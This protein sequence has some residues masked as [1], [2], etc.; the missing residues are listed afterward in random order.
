MTAFLLNRRNEANK[1][2]KLSPFTTALIAET[3]YKNITILSR[4]AEARRVG[5]AMP[6]VVTVCDMMPGV[7]LKRFYRAGDASRAIRDTLDSEMWIAWRCMET[8][9]NWPP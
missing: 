1:R 8:T 2:E 4:V 7:V 9:S 5:C 6:V 3:R